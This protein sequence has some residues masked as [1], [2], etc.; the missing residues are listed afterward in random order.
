MMSKMGWSPGQPL[1][2]QGL[3]EPLDAGRPS[4]N[5]RA[6]L[7]FKTS[8]HKRH[9]KAMPGISQNSTP[10]P[11][12]HG[13][14][15]EDGTITYGYPR[16]ITNPN[17][18]LGHITAEMLDTVTLTAQGKPRKTGESRPAAHRL[19]HPVL[20]W[21]G[22]V[23]GIA[24]FSFPHPRGWTYEGSPLGTT[25]EH[26]TIKRLTALFR[27]A[28]TSPPNCIAAWELAL[29]SPSPWNEIWRRTS[30]PIITPRDCKCQLTVIHRRIFTRNH[31][32]LAP[33][34]LCRCCNRYRETL[35]HLGV[36]TEF[37]KVW[38]RF[39]ALTGIPYSPALIYLGQTS[40]ITVLQGG[41]SALHLIIWKFLL[42]V[43][44]QV[45]TE[46]IK[47]NPDRVWK[48]ALWRLKDR[49]IAYTA[50]ASRN[51]RTAHNNG[52]PPP[53]LTTQNR[54]LEPIAHLEQR[55]AHPGTTLILSNPTRALFKEAGIDFKQYDTARTT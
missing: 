1:T 35:S 9:A 23:K 43:F 2:P 45:D 54:W 19:L 3:I 44:T 13:T 15:N 24:E 49:L 37:G 25:L 36:C 38:S 26:M 46:R 32:A 53:P 6:G 7:G 42:I 22:G 39:L 10:P 52:R 40:P 41:H 55:E 50:R 48:N 8:S 5:P 29:G 21:D 47:F 17:P 18:S 51:A 20:W 34:N 4:L 33:T 27:Q 16:T 12:L 30:N 14:E 28:I 11:L 31:N